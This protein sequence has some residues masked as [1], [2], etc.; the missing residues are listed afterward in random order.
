MK[1]TFGILFG[2]VCVAVAALA[3]GLSDES[4]TLPVEIPDAEKVIHG[5][6]P[7]DAQMVTNIEAIAYS[8][9]TNMIYQKYRSEDLRNC[10]WSPSSRIFYRGEIKRIDGEDRMYYIAITNVNLFT[11]GVPEELRQ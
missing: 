11:I 5:R 1:K 9:V 7:G 8:I 4:A 3:A 10:F 2:C 6:M